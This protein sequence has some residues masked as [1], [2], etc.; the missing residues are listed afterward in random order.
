[1][2]ERS[3]DRE[4]QERQKDLTW[5]EENRTLF[6]LAATVAFEELGYGA[7]VVDLISKPFAHG[8]SFGYYTEGEMEPQG[9]ELRRHLRD[10]NPD[11]EFI[12]LLLKP[13]G[14]KDVYLYTRPPIGW[15]ANL[16]TMTQYA[17]L[18]GPA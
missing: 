1:M 3:P 9:P 16:E 14:Q 6:W 4:D 18:G 13:G 12:V 8:H 7:V 17:Q 11:R 5:I 15:E 2:E 10:Y